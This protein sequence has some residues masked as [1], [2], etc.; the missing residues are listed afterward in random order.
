MADLFSPITIGNH[1]VKNRVVLPP[2]VVCGVH[3]DGL[4]NDAVVAHYESF[5][6]GGCGIIVQEATCVLPEGKLA[7]EQLVLFDDSHTDGMRRIADRVIPLGALLLMQIHY[8]STE[9]MPDNVR[10]IG[11]SEYMGREGM[12]RALSTTEVE[13]IR[14]GF[15]AAAVR[16]EKA[17]YHGVELHAAH[18]YLLCAFLNSKFNRRSD[19]YGDTTAL[20]REIIE[21][22]RQSTG[23]DF[24]VTARIG[25]D[26]P[27]LAT[28]IASC[29]AL[30]P[31]L[32]LL[33]LS[34]GM[35]REEP[36]PVPEGFPFVGL[37][38]LAC[39]AKKSLTKPVIAVGCLD[40]P[41]R[42]QQLISEGYADF[43]AIGRGLLVDPEWANKTQAGLPVMR[44]RRCKRCVWFKEQEK[45]P[46][47]LAK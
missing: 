24:L 8:A 6:R 40:E 46:G 44:C 28:G 39:E 35:G 22:I 4:V 14:D 1:K 20:T 7:G 17:G 37:A 36:L 15:V 26:N 5:A 16:A 27:D 19:R 13:R 12:C 23:P 9:G 18:G 38:W 41:G 10:P 21:G 31:S 25:I 33:N 42:A 29:K 32:D 2:L 11:P 45:C 43:A 34:H 3:P 47:R 30:E